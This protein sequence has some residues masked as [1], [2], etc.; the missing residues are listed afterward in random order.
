MRC[1][2]IAL[3]SNEVD[4]LR[5]S[6]AGRPS[7]S[8]SGSCAPEA[9]VAA[10]GDGDARVPLG[11][12]DEAGDRARR[13]RRGRGGRDRPR[14][15]GRARRARP[16][17]TC[18]P[19]RRACRFDGRQPD[20]APGRAA[21]LLRPRLRRPRR[22]ARAAAPR[23]RS[24]TTCARRC[25]SRS[26]CAARFDGRPAPG[27]YG[28]L[29]DLLAFGARAARA[30]AG[31]GGD[32]RRG[33]VRAVPGPRRRAARASAARSRT[34]GASA[35]SCATRSRRTGRAP[36]NSPRT[37]GH[38]GRS[39]TFLWVDPDAGVALACLTDRDFGDW[40]KEAWPALS[41]AVLAEL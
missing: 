30:D 29:D 25:S 21:H 2:S 38:F 16:S 20:R 19:T 26:A 36:R 6:R 5:P 7:T 40:A 18:S 8:R 13:A 32:A 4:A 41:D 1:R 35:S 34:T 3:V 37:F 17:A 11:V 33:D 39:G 15:A 12:G 23:C 31:R 24:P 9:V 22:G 28:S 14:R 10:H 27:I